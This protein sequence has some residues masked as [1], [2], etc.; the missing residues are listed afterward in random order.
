MVFIGGLMMAIAIEYWELHRRVAIKI[1]LMAGSEPRWLMLGM[2]LATWFLSM[3]ISNT[4]TTAMMIPIAEAILVQLKGT[5]TRLGNRVEKVGEV[6]ALEMKVSPSKE[7]KEKQSET[8][9]VV[10]NGKVGNNAQEKQPTQEKAE[11]EADSYSETEDEDPHFKQLC[12]G[13]SLS[14]CYAANSGGIA[15]LTGTGPNLA[16]KAHADQ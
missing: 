2:M 7:D 5:S 12:K 1:L 10:E 16:L 9:V 14:I 8:A 11:G 6:N 15:T 13:M 3:W 4:A